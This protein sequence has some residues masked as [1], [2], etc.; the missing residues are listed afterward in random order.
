M[1]IWFHF[2]ALKRKPVISQRILWLFLL[3]QFNYH[4]IFVFPKIRHILGAIQLLYCRML[5]QVGSL[6]PLF[7]G[8]PTFRILGISHFCGVKSDQSLLNWVSNCRQ[9]RVS[10][11]QRRHCFWSII[12]IFVIQDRHGNYLT[13]LLFRLFQWNF[14]SFALLIGEFFAKIAFILL[15][16]FNIKHGLGY[17]SSMLVSDRFLRILLQCK[18]FNEIVIVTCCQIVFFR[19][20]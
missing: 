10:A 14:T 7:I 19:I 3:W 6:H 1:W 18:L 16:D 8:K 20:F 13:S 9:F 12:L 15:S 11:T 5:L 2:R 4:S 17:G